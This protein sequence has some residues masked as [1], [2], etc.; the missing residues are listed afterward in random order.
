MLI[1]G[2]MTLQQL[3]A[4][5]Y[6]LKQLFLSEGGREFLEKAANISQGAVRA[7]IDQFLSVIQQSK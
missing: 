4:S 2:L 1:S 3:I 7:H 6:R 5:E